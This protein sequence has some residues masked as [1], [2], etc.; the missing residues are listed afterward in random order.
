MRAELLGNPLKKLLVIANLLISCFL[1]L[2]V[3][4]DLQEMLVEDA[5]LG[6]LLVVRNLVVSDLLQLHEFESKQGHLFN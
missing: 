3:G 5:V 4:V 1:D 2:A 6:Q